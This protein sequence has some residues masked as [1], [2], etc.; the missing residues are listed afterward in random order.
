M[1][2]TKTAP[3]PGPRAASARYRRTTGELV[4]IYENGATLTVPVALVQELA[5]LAPS[6]A[7]LSDIE[8]W[9]GG[10][11]LYFPRLDAFVHGPALLAGAFGSRA[12]MREL[13]RNLGSVTSPA[14]AAAAR[15]NG[16]KGGRPRKDAARATPHARAA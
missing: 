4:V 7:D 11:D 14:K 2:T 12:W 6:A 13:A 10:F 1:A 5:R 9:G 15:E 8:I 16:R 3:P